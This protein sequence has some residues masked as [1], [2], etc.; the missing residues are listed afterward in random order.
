MQA[1]ESQKVTLHYISL[2]VGGLIY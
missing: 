1:L 2:G